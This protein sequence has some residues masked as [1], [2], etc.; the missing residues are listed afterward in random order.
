MAACQST[1]NRCG[2]NNQG[3]T[4]CNVNS[5]TA[6][7]VAKPSPYSNGGVLAIKYTFVDQRGP[8]VSSR[9]F[10]STELAKDS[11]ASL[12]VRTSID[13]YKLSFTNTTDDT[14]RV[15]SVAPFVLTRTAP[16]TTTIVPLPGGVEVDAALPLDL[17]L[18]QRYSR[19]TRDGQPFF[20]T[21]SVILKPHAS[22]DLSINARIGHYYVDFRLDV[23]YITTD[24]NAHTIAYKPSDPYFRVFA[25]SSFAESS[26][27]YQDFWNFSQDPQTGAYTYFVVPKGPE[28]DRLFRT[29][30]RP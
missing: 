9:R 13:T 28:R 8:L 25:L 23:T 5:N 1:T 6:L 29:C 18:D 24:G 11:D 22:F 30:C 17:D 15:T 3:T 26:S 14:I 12:F 27:S 20:D 19:L 2:S 10:T 4:I 21:N 16:L 7:A